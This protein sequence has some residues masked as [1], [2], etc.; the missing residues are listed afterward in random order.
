MHDHC[1]APCGWVAMQGWRRPMALNGTGIEFGKSEHVRR[2]RISRATTIS[3]DFIVL[4]QQCGQQV[5]G[6]KVGHTTRGHPPVSRM[7]MPSAHGSTVTTAQVTQDPAGPTHGLRRGST[8]LTCPPNAFRTGHTDTIS[9][10]AG[11]WPLA[12]VAGCALRPSRLR[13]TLDVNTKIYH[14]TATVSASPGSASG[15]G[16]GAQKQ[17]CS[18]VT[19]CGKLAFHACSR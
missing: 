19:G 5:S 10:Q 15:G 14:V 16:G 9:V 7:G 6:R 11:R 18:P 2:R 12:G 17:T 3:A 13:S 8:I 4:G 1:G